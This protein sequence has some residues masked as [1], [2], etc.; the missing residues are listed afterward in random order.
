MSRKI[1]IISRNC[2][3]YNKGTQ[4]SNLIAT[5]SV[6]INRCYVAAYDYLKSKHSTNEALVS[7]LQSTGRNDIRLIKDF[8]TQEE[9]TNWYE[10]PD[11]LI[12]YIGDTDKKYYDKITHEG[13]DI[14]IFY[15][16]NTDNYASIPCLLLSL[17]CKDCEI[18]ENSESENY[19]Y[20]HA[21]EW[22]R[23]TIGKDEGDN[24]LIYEKRKDSSITTN[25]ELIEELIKR[26]FTFAASFKHI[27]SR[28]HF[29]F[30]MLNLKFGKK[31]LLN[32]IKEVER[33]PNNKDFI[34]LKNRIEEL[35]NTWNTN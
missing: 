17:V 15:W 32:A 28:G 9:K 35:C 27:N 10:I 5:A 6:P 16:D 23:G 3:E 22:R 29:F 30:Q 8:I 11:S 26:N 14:Y 21:G 33:S 1:I 7:Y 25:K 18:D 4:L 12:D 2:H 13:D 31:I 20:I 19:L 24:L 34:N